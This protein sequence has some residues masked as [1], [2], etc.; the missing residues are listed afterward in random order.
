VGIEYPKQHEVSDMLEEMKKRYPPWFV[1][2]IPFVQETS[3]F[4]F[5]KRELAFYGGEEAFLS[6][7]EVVSKEDSRKAVSSAEKVYALCNSLVSEL[8][9]SRRRTSRRA[10]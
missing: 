2:Q 8:T 1:Q 9:P 5:K 6:P 3:R 7:E 10:R 4:L